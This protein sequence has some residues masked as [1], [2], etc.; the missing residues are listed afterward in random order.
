ME[1]KTKSVEIER[2]TAGDR[3]YDSQNSFITPRFFVQEEAENLT[4]AEFLLPPAL[5]SLFSHVQR[6]RR[7]FF[8]NK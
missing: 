6:E 3:D 8:Y 7:L 1:Q 2:Q 4:Y 5:F